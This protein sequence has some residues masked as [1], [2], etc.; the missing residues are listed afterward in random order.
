MQQARCDIPTFAAF[1]DDRN[2]FPVV[3]R[4]YAN[5]HG[6]TFWL[7][8]DAVADPEVKHARVGACLIQEPQAF[9]NAVV[10]INQFLLREVVDVN[11]H[12]D[13]APYG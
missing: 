9:D 10:E 3:P 5:Q 12:N 11:G 8:R 6:S 7:K 1:G 13:S 4:E 2:S